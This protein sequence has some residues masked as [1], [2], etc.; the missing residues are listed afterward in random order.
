[1]EI[2]N[3]FIRSQIVL[4]IFSMKK[5]HHLNL[6]QMRSQEMDEYQKLIVREKKH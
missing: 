2:S 6:K 5:P 3:V 4:I 1:M